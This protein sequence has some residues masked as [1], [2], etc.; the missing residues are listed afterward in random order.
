[1]IAESW[2]WIIPKWWPSENQTEKTPELLRMGEKEFWQLETIM[3]GWQQARMTNLE[4]NGARLKEE[5]SL[6]FQTENDDEKY[7]EELGRCSETMNTRNV[8]SKLKRIWKRSQR[9]RMTDGIHTHDILWKEFE[10]HS[11]KELEESGKILG[12]DMWVRAHSKETPL[13]WLLEKR[14]CTSWIRRYWCYY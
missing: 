2:E 6:V 10:N 11:G 12:K 7:R 13:K 8:E 5:S 1:M 4:E 9:S 3:R 14:Y